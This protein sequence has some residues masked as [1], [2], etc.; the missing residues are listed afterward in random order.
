MEIEVTYVD[1]PN[2][3]YCRFFEN[4]QK[5]SKLM[6]QLTDYAGDEHLLIVY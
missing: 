1:Y 4:E 3:F 6:A 2:L 5:F